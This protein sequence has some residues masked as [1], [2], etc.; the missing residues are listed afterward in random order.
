MNEQ[1][2]YTNEQKVALAFTGQSA[3]F[4]QL[5][6]TNGIVTYKRERVRKHLMKY[7]DP[8]SR[9][10]ELNAG[11]GDDAIFLAKQGHYVHATDI[12]SGMQVKLIEKVA[13]HRMNSYVSYELCSFTSLENL[14]NKG[15]YDCIFSNF[16]GLNCTGDLEKVLS[17][18]EYLLKPGGMVLL[19][20]LPGFCLWETLFILRGKFKTATRRFLSS[21][22]T[23]ANID[24]ASFTCW[25]YSPRFIMNKLKHKFK[26]I[27]LEGLC[28]I[29]P[30]SYIEKF[31]EK[32]SKVYG[33]L[34]KMENRFKGSWP[35]KYIGDYYI[36]SL[37]KAHTA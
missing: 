27:E 34:C 35:W 14:L 37:R 22:G 6:A 26:V 36:I 33:W 11:T 23:K 20:M 8:G 9:I 25:Y 15:P 5:Y 32:Y 13:L 1:K 30:P 17:S 12:S 2:N 4:D 7:L 24:G 10:L 31:P 28:T 19:V 29:V 18:F 16:A 21:N 3:I